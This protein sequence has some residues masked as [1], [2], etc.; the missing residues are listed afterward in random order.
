MP[1]K[2]KIAQADI[3]ADVLKGRREFYLALAG[4]YFKPLTQEQIDAMAGTDFTEFAADEPMLADGFNDITRFLRKR[5]TGT[6]QTLAVDFT[7]SFGGTEAY[8]GRVAVPYASVYLSEEGLLSRA[9]RAEVF[10]VFS[11]NLL[12]VTD[13][14][15]PD[16]HLS[17]MLEF[18]SIMSGRAAEAIQDGQAADA[19]HCLEESRDFIN[20]HI[21]TW[22]MD[23]ATL[24]NRFFETRFY[25]GVLKV[26]EGY[27][28]LDLQTIDDLL[29]ALNE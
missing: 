9:P 7:S 15:T 21:L 16:D 3:L 28:R 10:K 6:R 11:R 4:F 13:T 29:E 5:N 20:H 2:T 25:R 17:F 24:A 8:Q 18:L 19:R 12:R 27:L 26:T 23:F 1:T 14:S 22:F